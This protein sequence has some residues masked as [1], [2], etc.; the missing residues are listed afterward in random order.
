[1]NKDDKNELS[2]EQELERVRQDESI[3]SVRFS[4]EGQEAVF[5]HIAKYKENKALGISMEDEI[6]E[7]RQRAE[8]RIDDREQSPRV[9]KV[10]SLSDDERYKNLT[11]EE[12]KILMMNKEKEVQEVEVSM[13]DKEEK[14]Y[15]VKKRSKKMLYILA[16]AMV[17]SLAMG[18]VG[19]TS[20]YKEMQMSEKNA[21]EMQYQFMDSE[22]DMEE[23]VDIMSEQGALEQA[24]IFFGQQVMW[25]YGADFQKY[26]LLENAEKMEVLFSVNDYTWILQIFRNINKISEFTLTNEILIDRKEFIERGICFEFSYYEDLSTGNMTNMVVWSDNGLHYRLILGGELVQSVGEI[27]ELLKNIQ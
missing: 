22:I 19:V 14:T 8:T 11:P 1:M 4:K 21:E 6:N 27:E 25:L 23:S 18:T 9:S 16:A 10:R 15:T 5:A 24:K 2:Y 12:R 20:R 7:L 17:M 13:E 26:T 3:E